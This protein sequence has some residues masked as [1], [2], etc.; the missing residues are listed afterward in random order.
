MNTIK[1]IVNFLI[2]RKS[3]D[4]ILYTFNKVQN[5]LDEFIEYKDDTIKVSKAEIEELKMMIA[6]Q[7]SANAHHALEIQKAA[8]VKANIAKLILS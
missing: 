2:P 5:E 7:E 3:L 6:N 4:S 1:K 8:A